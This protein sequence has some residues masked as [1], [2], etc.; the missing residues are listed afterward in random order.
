[1]RT[2]Y[3]EDIQLLSHKDIQSIVT[4]YERW[5]LKESRFL[6]KHKNDTAYK[7]NNES[8][9]LVLYVQRIVESGETLAE[10]EA[11]LK[12][13]GYCFKHKEEGNRT[14]ELNAIIMKIDKNYPS[15]TGRVVEGYLFIDSQL[16]LY[17]KKKSFSDK[18]FIHFFFGENIDRCHQDDDKTFNPQNDGSHRILFYE[19][20]EEISADDYE[21]LLP[22]YQARADE[23]N[24]YY[25]KEREELIEEYKKGF[26]I[27]KKHK[28]NSLI[29]YTPHQVTCETQEDLA[30]ALE[31][32]GY[33]FKHKETG[34][35]TEQRTAK[36]LK[37]VE[38][39]KTGETEKFRYAFLGFKEE[40][41]PVTELSQR[42]DG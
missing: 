27:Y 28:Y 34:E 26:R 33:K 37:I 18:A 17:E 38:S 42:F 1:M 25:V 31:P 3:Y 12:E 6:V 11:K 14:E 39:S 19:D 5:M 10:F 36:L 13:L 21:A 40:I 15:W 20:I 35:R 41:R 32:Y 24:E 16:F 4:W 2:L 22:W 23:L 9:E 30:L 8:S 29:C 7:L